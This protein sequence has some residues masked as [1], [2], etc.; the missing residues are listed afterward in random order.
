MTMPQAKTT[1]RELFPPVTLFTT[2]VEYKPNWGEGN[3][4]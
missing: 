4:I 1:E 2:V 3:P